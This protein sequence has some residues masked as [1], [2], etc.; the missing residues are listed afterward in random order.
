M[1]IFLPPLEIDDD[2]GFTAEK[3]LFGRKDFGDGLTRLVTNVD[4]PLVIALDG[5]WGSGKTTFLKMWAGEL[6]KQGFPV[7]FFDAFANDYMTDAFMALAG[8]IVTLAEK[9]D[10]RRSARSDE[11]VTQAKRVGKVLLRSSLKIALK[12]AT[13]G[14]LDSE[15]LEGVAKEATKDI[16]KEASDLEDKYIGELLTQQAQEK[17][18]IEGFKKSL[19]MLSG[20]LTEEIPAAENGSNTQKK[21]LVF[22]IDEL[23]RCRP[24][25]ALSLLE[26]IKHFFSVPNVFFVL[27]FHGGQLE[28]S[29]R[30]F[31]GSGI[32]AHNYL[33]KFIHFS[34]T[35][36]S[37][38]DHRDVGSREARYVAVLF[39]KHEFPQNRL[40]SETQSFLSKLVLNDV[41]SLRAVERITSSFA[42]VIAFRDRRQALRDDVIRQ[43]I[44]ICLIIIKVISEDL[45]R[46]AKDGTLDFGEFLSRLKISLSESPHREEYFVG[47]WRYLLTGEDT[48]RFDFSSRTDGA[49]SLELIQDCARRIVERTGRQ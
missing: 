29:V 7:V 41:L 31:Y 10:K 37:D 30:A 35:L 13:L 26:R 45:Y 47:L 15:A 38:E 25:F 2:E 6:R 3:D 33:Q 1:K 11:F 18:A 24:D 39:S 14:V 23:D 9:T 28:N 4:D 46:K 20:S 19:E 40:V 49:D 42:L 34:F 22:I 12:S 48:V 36:R 8:Q 16:A 17:D 5:Q 27:G 21:R 43:E 44:A 32:D